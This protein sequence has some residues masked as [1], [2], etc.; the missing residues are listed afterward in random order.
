[1]FFREKNRYLFKKLW[2]EKILEDEYC[3]FFINYL[4]INSLFVYLYSEKAY[5]EK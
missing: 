1:M 5:Y 3:D 4:V 2:L